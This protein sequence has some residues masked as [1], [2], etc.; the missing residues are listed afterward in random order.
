MLLAL[1]SLFGLVGAFIVVTGGNPDRSRYVDGV[2]VVIA[3]TAVWLSVTSM[4]RA[5]RA[6]SARP[7][8]A[9][10]AT[11]IGVIGLVFTALLL[12]TFVAY[13]PQLSQYFRCMSAATTTSAQQACRQKLENQ[14]SVL[15]G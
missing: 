10:A 11:V 9:I 5:R 6:G 4:S 8:V 3:A 7:R 1:I 12:P 13:S 15:G 2:A 14:V